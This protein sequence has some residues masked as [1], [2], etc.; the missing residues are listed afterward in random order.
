MDMVPALFRM[1]AHL[2]RPAPL[3]H[4]APAIATAGSAP[5]TLL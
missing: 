3:L 2:K 1:A 4:H 5:M